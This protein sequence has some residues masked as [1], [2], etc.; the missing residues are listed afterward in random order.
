MQ[1]DLNLFKEEEKGNNEQGTQ[2]NVD[3]GYEDDRNRRGRG[4]EVRR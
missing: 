4:E 1:T 3:A 2:S